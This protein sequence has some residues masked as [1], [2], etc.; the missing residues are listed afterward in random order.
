[1]LSIITATYDAAVHVPRLIESLA[2]QS[3][4]NFEWVVQDGGSSDN[5]LDLIGG[6][7]VPADIRSS[8][9]AGIYDALNRGLARAKGRYLIFLG[10]DDV[11]HDGAVVRDVN[12]ALESRSPDVLLAQAIAGPNQT[13]VTSGLSWRSLVVNTIHHQGAVYGAHLFSDFRYDEKLRVCADYE[14]TLQ[15]YRRRAELRI[16]HLGRVLTTCGAEGV[17]HMHDEVGNYQEM[18]V[19]RRRHLP[20]VLASPLHQAA[21]LNMR[22]RRR[23]RG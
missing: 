21:M 6:A 10:A 17:S 8:P 7:S 12:L 4:Q 22:R 5:T 23:N 13:V 15:L 2:I 9:D 19:V 18:D 3:D 11:L 1:M 14:L 16:A 20:S